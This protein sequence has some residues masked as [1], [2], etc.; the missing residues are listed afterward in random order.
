M[1]TIYKVVFP[2]KNGI[3]RDFD[4]DIRKLRYFIVIAEEKQLT[5]AAQRLHMAQP[6]LSRQ[7]SLLEQELS[8]NLFERNGRNM[9]LTEEGKNFIYESKKTLFIN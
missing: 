2:Y 7:L 3:E 4:M 1:K 9:H 5:R 8:V 6:P